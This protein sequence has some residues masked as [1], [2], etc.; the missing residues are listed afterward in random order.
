MAF[1]IVPLLIHNPAIPAE[2]REALKAASFAPAE[3]RRRQ[4]ESAARA[5]LLKAGLDCGDARELV[6][7]HCSGPC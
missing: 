5:L 2:A 1:S 7:L 4:L 6:G 3:Q